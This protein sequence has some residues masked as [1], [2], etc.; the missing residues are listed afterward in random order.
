[1][2]IDQ[3]EAGS[4]AQSEQPRR[5]QEVGPDMHCVHVICILWLHMKLLVCNAMLCA[6]QCN[7]M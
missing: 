6:M 5:E 3:R 2:D 1:M 7:D 4:P